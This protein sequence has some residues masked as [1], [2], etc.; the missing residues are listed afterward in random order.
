MTVKK[1]FYFSFL[2]GS[3]SIVTP[4]VFAA[5]FSTVETDLSTSREVEYLIPTETSTSG[6]T[7]LSDQGSIR[8]FFSNSPLSTSS[9]TETISNTQT[10]TT[11]TTEGEKDPLEIA[12]NIIEEDIR[13]EPGVEDD[14]FLVT[15][16]NYFEGD[17]PK[18]EP[19]WTDE[20]DAGDGAIIWIT[21][22]DTNYIYTFV[23]DYDVSNTQ[24]SPGPL[25]LI[26]VSDHSDLPF[27]SEDPGKDVD[28]NTVQDEIDLLS[29]I[30]VNFF[31]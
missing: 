4:V 6:D 16:A 29:N 15:V 2:L 5:N 19:Y 28:I 11:S 27:G 21:D 26:E 12:E 1:I 18:D 13:N 30:L 25:E 8:D 14:R 7:D 9:T 10:N 23:Y 17:P 31:S 22:T 3:L 24:S 20:G